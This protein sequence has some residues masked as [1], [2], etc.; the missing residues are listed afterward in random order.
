[1][2]NCFSEL[3]NLTSVTFGTN[4]TSI[5]IFAFEGCTGLTSVTIP[6]SVI[7]IDDSAFWRCSRLTAI[8]VDSLNPAYSSLDG[9]LF[10]RGQDKLVTYPAGKPGSYV[11]PDT[12]TTIGDF[13]FY[14]CSGLANVTIPNSVTTI[15]YAAFEGC[16]GLTSV[17]IPES[18]TSLEN[19]A[20][21]DCTRLT[22]VYFRGNAPRGLA[23]WVFNDAPNVTVYYRAGRVGWGSTFGDYPA[24]PAVRW[25]P[26]IPVNH[27]SLG[28][29]ADGF[30]FRITGTTNI[31]VVVE[32][33]TDL[34][35]GA[36]VPLQSASLTNGWFDFV[37]AGWTNYPARFYRISSP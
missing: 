1:V 22:G 35:S 34:A 18:V 5:D 7:D 32:G 33:C 9:V 19:H 6:K 21:E 3:T 15:E 31:P 26:L 30:G 29:R 11:V 27:P 37:D 8:T 23:F 25:E 36:W 4:V 14:C 24:V 12:V 20:F 2:T 28:V 10:N 17:T 16:T 13:A